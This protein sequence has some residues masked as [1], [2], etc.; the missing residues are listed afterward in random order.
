MFFII[1]NINNLPLMQ[2]NVLILH[3]IVTTIF[4]FSII[5]LTKK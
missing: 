5:P 1:A 4:Y 2:L 3:R